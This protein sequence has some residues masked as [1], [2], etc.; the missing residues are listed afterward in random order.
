MSI[1]VQEKI[2]DNLAT[3]VAAVV[4]ADGANFPFAA[5]GP[6]STQSMPKSRAEIRAGGFV[7]ASDQMAQ[8]AAGAW[9]YPHRRGTLT[10]AVVSQRHALTAIGP[11]SKHGDAIGRFRYLMSIVVRALQPADVSNYQI[12]DIVDQGDFY[13]PGSATECD[14]TEIRFAVD[15]WLP[16]ASYSAT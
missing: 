16:P 3:G 8:N 13:T 9:F 15:L 4:T 12:M 2:G 6:R 10:C 1:T 5:F 7:R 14:R 11:D